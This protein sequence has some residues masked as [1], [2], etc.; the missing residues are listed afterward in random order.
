[1]LQSDGFQFR[2]DMSDDELVGYLYK[3]GGINSDLISNK[4]FLDFLLPTLRS[5]FKIC[6][7]LMQ[8]KNIPVLDIPLKAV[9]GSHD[10]LDELDLA[11]WCRV[12]RRPHGYKMLPGKHFYFVGNEIEFFNVIFGDLVEP[13]MN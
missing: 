8:L 13:H 1:L 5:D 11:D 2:S 7:N 10:D 6:E 4:G 12:S 9:G 3:Q